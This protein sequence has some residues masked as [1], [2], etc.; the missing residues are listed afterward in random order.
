MHAWEISMKREEAYCY[1]AF[2]LDQPAGDVLDQTFMLYVNGIKEPFVTVE[3]LCPLMLCTTH[4][5]LLP[6]PPL[7]D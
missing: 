3:Q 5:A 7:S 4:H 6:L 2:P 1:L